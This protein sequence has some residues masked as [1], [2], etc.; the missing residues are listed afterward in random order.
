[1]LYGVLVSSEDLKTLCLDAAYPTNAVCMQKSFYVFLWFLVLILIIHTYLTKETDYIIMM[2]LKFLIII[3]QW[4]W[5]LILIYSVCFTFFNA[6]I[7]I[8]SSGYY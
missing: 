7:L 2:V 1:M 4:C 3:W 5:F 8:W 6:H